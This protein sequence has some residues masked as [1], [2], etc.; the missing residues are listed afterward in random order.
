LA[1]ALQV[2]LAAVVAGTVAVLETFVAGDFAT[3]SR[4]AGR[5]V[6]IRA[7]LMTRSAVE[8]VRL[9]VDLAAIARIPVAIHG[10]SVAAVGLD[11]A[12]PAAALR[13]SVR[14]IAGIPARSAV[15]GVRAGVDLAVVV[16]VEVAVGEPIQ[17]NGTAALVV[18]L[19]TD[20]VGAQRARL[21][22]QARFAAVPSAVHVRFVGV[23][24]LIL[25][26]RDHDDVAVPTHRRR[27]R[28]LE[29]ELGDAASAQRES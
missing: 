18:A 2:H 5:A 19:L 16:I 22:R 21:A 27:R 14:Q 3:A 24:A 6:Q 15:L 1:A 10:A 28:W 25:A 23:E 20:A 8:L 29:S 12:L 9:Q 4:A 26:V 17:A 13:G 7:N 11:A